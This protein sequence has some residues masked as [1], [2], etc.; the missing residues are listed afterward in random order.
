MATY[1]H[2][3]DGRLRVRLPE[4]RGDR[5]AAASLRRELRALPGVSTV[6]VSPL[7]GSVLVE[8]DADRLSTDEV[9]GAAGV[10]A[11]DATGDTRRGALFDAGA[12]DRSTT[13]RDVVAEKVIELAAERL[14]LAVLA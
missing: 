10:E 12:A 14:L 11:P 13:V 2:A 9:L 7:T 5:R 8:Y 1:L 4:L 6:D 3:I